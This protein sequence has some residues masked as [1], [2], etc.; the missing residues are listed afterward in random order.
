MARQWEGKH[1]LHFVGLNTPFNPQHLIR[2]NRFLWVAVDFKQRQ[3]APLWS[4]SR[5]TTEVVQFCLSLPEA[6]KT[7]LILFPQ[8]FWHD[9]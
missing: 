4:D 9:W 6:E 5:L 8:N 3:A 2:L 7:S 1:C